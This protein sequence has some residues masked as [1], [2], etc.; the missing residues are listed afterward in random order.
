L[1]DAGVFGSSGK[2]PEIGE[3]SLGDGG[4]PVLK[5]DP[6]P[7]RSAP[8]EEYPLDAACSLRACK[9]AL[10]MSGGVVFG[11]TEFWPNAFELRLTYLAKLVDCAL[12]L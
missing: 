11:G 10:K 4:E 3:L 12:E 5:V 6:V 9:K 1:R 2:W 7:G 8:F